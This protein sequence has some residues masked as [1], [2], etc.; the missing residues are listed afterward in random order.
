MFRAAEKREKEKWR[1]TLYQMQ[2]LRD[3][4]TGVMGGK[5]KGTDYL[6]KQTFGAAQK[7]KKWKSLKEFQAHIKQAHAKVLAKHAKRK[8][9]RGNNS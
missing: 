7:R 2:D 1:H 5:P 4:V 8:R 9:R 6:F 3:T